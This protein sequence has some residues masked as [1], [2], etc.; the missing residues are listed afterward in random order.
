VI[1]SGGSGGSGGGAQVR[2][3][4]EDDDLRTGLVALE[5]LA[6]SERELSDVLTRVAQSAVL[7][8]P[9]ADG[10]G[11]T[12]LQAGRVQTVAASAPFVAEIDAIQ[13]RIAEGPC[14]TC[15]ALARTVR[16]G[17]LAADPQ[18]P[19]LGRRIEHLGVH[20]ALSIPLQTPDGVLGAMTVYAYTP[21]A[22]DERGVR[23]GELF[24]VPAA[25][26][27]ENARVLAQAKLLAE[28]LQLAV[29]NQ[30]VIDRATG[31]VMSRLACSPDQALEQLRQSRQTEDETLHTLALRIVEGALNTPTKRPRGRPVSYG[32]ARSDLNLAVWYRDT[33][34]SILTAAGMLTPGTADVLTR[35]L[36]HQLESGHRYVHLD[37]S[38]LLACDRDGALAIVEAHHA[39][40]AADGTLVLAGA[41]TALRQLLHLLGVDTVLFLARARRGQ[42]E[43]RPTRPA[44]PREDRDRES[45][46]YP[47][48]IP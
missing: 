43:R 29:A 38:E 4:G 46:V 2:V 48:Q 25:I 1:G 39:F 28:Q 32:S 41:G 37:V 20:S 3:A 26:A 18:W 44:A 16:S 47:K 5:Y 34:H 8:V 21:D 40:L 19:R 7:A 10:A 6:T 17:T 36:K 14:I 11:L 9:G 45:S 12:L 30:A 42:A 22:F 13:Y 23:I 15:A 24:A 31:I 27:V 35:A 33:T